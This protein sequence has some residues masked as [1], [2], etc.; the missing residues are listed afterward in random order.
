MAGNINLTIEQFSTWQFGLT[1][2]DPAGSP[3]DLTAATA[4]MEIRSSPEGT[5][6]ETLSTAGGEITIP[7]P[8]TGEMTL[9]LTAVQTSA[10][11]FDTAQYDLVV[12]FP[13]GVSTRV[14]E[15]LCRLSEGV[16]EL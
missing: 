7:T 5:L 13:T 8:L 9:E 4:K 3:V 11:D 2:Q 1:I 14:I 6:L 10:L 12:T 16:T 15:G